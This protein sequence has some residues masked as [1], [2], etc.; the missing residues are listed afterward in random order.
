[1][2]K[3]Y[4]GGSAAVCVESTVEDVRRA[5]DVPSGFNLNVGLVSYID[6]RKDYI[7]VDEPIRFFFSKSKYYDFEKAPR[8]Q[9]SCRLI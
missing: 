9:A 2:W 1:M 4:G 6:Y 8:C 5:M 3:T 7:G